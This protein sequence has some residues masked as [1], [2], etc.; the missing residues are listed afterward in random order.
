MGFAVVESEKTD[1]KRV[2]VYDALARSWHALPLAYLPFSYLVA[3]D[4]GLLCFVKYSKNTQC[5]QVAV[6]NPLTC[7]CREL[8]PALGVQMFPKSFQLKVDMKTRQYTIKFLGSYDIKEPEVFH[9][10]SSERN[11]WAR[12]DWSRQPDMVERY[13]LIN[14]YLGSIHTYDIKPGATSTILYPPDFDHDMVAQVE[15]SFLFQAEQ[16]CLFLLKTHESRLTGGSDQTRW[17]HFSRIPKDAELHN[18]FF[19]VYLCGNSILLLG[20]KRKLF[21]DISHGFEDGDNNTD[22]T[23][24]LMLDLS[25][26]T[27]T[28]VTNHN[29][30]PSCL[31]RYSTEL[32]LDAIP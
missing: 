14:V 23:L 24:M 29:I 18:Y 27:W 7:A 28:D 10:Y 32:R 21:Y 31:S 8:P 20:K 1:P 22:P 5:L 16:G 25:T 17:E 30:D 15:G 3:A 26:K 6:M 11:A 2:W 13:I 19:S 4:G 12:Q 9:V